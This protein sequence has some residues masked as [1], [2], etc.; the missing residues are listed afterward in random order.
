MKDKERINLFNVYKRGKWLPSLLSQG[1]MLKMQE[2]NYNN[3]FTT[4]ST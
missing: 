4:L 2:L 1:L 3:Q